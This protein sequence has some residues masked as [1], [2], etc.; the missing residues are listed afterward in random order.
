[1]ALKVSVELEGVPELKAGLMELGSRMAQKKVAPGIRRKAA[2]YL[3]FAKER[4]PKDTG[5]LR[6]NTRVLPVQILFQARGIFGG[7]VPSDIVGGFEFREKYA[8][9]QHERIDFHHTEGQAKYAE[10]VLLEK[11]AEFSLFLGG[12]IRQALAGKA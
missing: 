4:A 2:D 9:I 8:A 11:R 5:L 7:A 6:E 12:L 1:V 10:S 3:G